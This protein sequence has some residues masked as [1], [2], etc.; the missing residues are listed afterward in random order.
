[1]FQISL[2]AARV[3]AKMTQREVAK[4]MNVN[5]ATIAN[6]EKGK[7]TLK[8]DQ[9]MRLCDIYKCPQDAIFLSKNLT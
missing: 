1:M 5:A 4:Q 3:N 8:V 6:W 9:F 2:E 7:T